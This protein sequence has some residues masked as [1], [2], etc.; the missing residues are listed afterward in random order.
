MF[1]TLLLPA[2]TAPHAR[3]CCKSAE[4]R[5]RACQLVMQARH[6]LLRQAL[7]L[8]QLQHTTGSRQQTMQRSRQ[9]RKLQLMQRRTG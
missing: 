6:L 9:Q 2:L 4:S 7:L 1:L 5:G 3:S 8:R